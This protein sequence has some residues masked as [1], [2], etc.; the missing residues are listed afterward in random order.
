MK[1]PRKNY[2]KIVVLPT[3]HRRDNWAEP[4]RQLAAQHLSTQLAAIIV[5]LFSI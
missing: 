5:Y 3:H 4:S 2:L 1:T